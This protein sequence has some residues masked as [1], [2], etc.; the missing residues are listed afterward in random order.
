MSGSLEK[1]CYKDGA[2]V[3]HGTRVND[4]CNEWY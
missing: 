2:R 4:N 1:D 3:N